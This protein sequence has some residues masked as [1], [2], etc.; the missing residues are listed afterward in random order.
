MDIWVIGVEM[1]K[2]DCTESMDTTI[3]YGG[4]CIRL[5]ACTLQGQIAQNSIRWKVRPRSNALPTS[6]GRTMQQDVPA[7]H[8]RLRR[9]PW[10]H[11]PWA[12]PLRS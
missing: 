4:P 3:E 7:S 2:L 12:V 9:H 11:V 5:L 6:R 1:N 8:R 10:G